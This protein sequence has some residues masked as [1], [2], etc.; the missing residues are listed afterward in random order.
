MA[1]IEKTLEL[2]ITHEI[3]SL[4]DSFWW[5]LQPISLKKYWRPNWRFPLIPQPKSFA[6][7]LHINLEGQKGGGYDVCIHSPSSF[8]GGKPRLLFMQFKAGI[9][10]DGVNDPK[11][12]FSLKKS[13]PNKHIEFTLNDNRAKL[14]QHQ[15]LHTLAKKIGNENAAV[16]VFPQMVDEI[17][18]SQNIGQLLRRTL[19]VSIADI[20]G[21]ALSN[22]VSL[23]DGNPHKFRL[24]YNNLFKSEVNLLLFLFGRPTFPGSILGEI[25]A[26]RVFRAL[27]ALKQTQLEDFPIHVT[28]VQ[29]ALIRHVAYIAYNFSITPRALEN[30]I[31]AN[32]NLDIDLAY[33]MLEEYKSYFSNNIMNEQ[34]VDI[35][36]DILNSISQYVIWAEN[37]TSFDSKTLIPNPPHNH[38]I[39]IPEGGL[40]FFFQTNE[41]NDEDFED[42]TYQL[43]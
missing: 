39:E 23:L 20:E 1:K 42:L 21:K 5:Y 26:I 12:I 11:S 25:F 7:G 40:R 34:V 19:F 38:T 15:L 43:F 10:N 14:K 4:A 31:A 22:G 41:F 30:I 3:L 6:T 28:H 27:L 17:Q 36:R 2:N 13:N 18:L 9:N 16:Y 32:E 33:D 24:C 8:V 29:Q 37:L 35:V